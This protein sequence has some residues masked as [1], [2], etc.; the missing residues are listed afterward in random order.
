MSLTIYGTPRSRTYRTLWMAEELGLAYEL[1]RIELGAASSDGPLRALNPSGRIPTIEDDGLPLW[2]SMAINCYLARKHGG[3]LAAADVAEEGQI[4][5]WSFW[6][7]TDCEPACFQ[8]LLHSV[9][10]PEARRRPEA[11]AEA[12]L[13]LHAPLGVIEGV[14]QGRDHLVGGRFTVGDLN[15]AA[16]LGWLVAARA[17]LVSWPATR[18]WLGRCAARPAARKATALVLAG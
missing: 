8:A 1:V 5:Q 14:L 6:V 11:V 16:V 9:L 10:L 2:E 15:V 7:M 4:L 18:G 12:V 13:K 3:P 17:D